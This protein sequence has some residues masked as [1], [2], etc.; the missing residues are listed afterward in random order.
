MEQI[1]ERNKPS[2]PKK[3]LP[4]APF[5]LF[6]IDKVIGENDATSDLIKEQFFSKKNKDQD[7]NKKKS[8][9]EVKEGIIN[10]KLLLRQPKSNIQMINE[11][12]KSLSPSGIELEF[13][14][15]S[16][17]DL[18]NKSADGVPLNYV[19]LMLNFFHDMIRSKQDS[20]FT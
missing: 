15:L 16:T 3:D 2:L 5:F 11:Y 1:K 18:D 9:T 20:D 13:L 6:D 7:D 4:K 17:F 14:S 10:L 19:L 12:L 8:L